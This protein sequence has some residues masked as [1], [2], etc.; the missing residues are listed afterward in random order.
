MLPRRVLDSQHCSNVSMTGC[1]HA[2]LVVVCV[3][4]CTG[5]SVS[6]VFR[7]QAMA[8]DDAESL[9]AVGIRAA[10]AA[11]AKFHEQLGRTDVVIT[12]L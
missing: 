6:L 2:P 10:V 7:I 9:A 3:C 11:T 8:D 5:S 12:C 1:E 4:L